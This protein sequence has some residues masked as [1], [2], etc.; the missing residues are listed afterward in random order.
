VTPADLKILGIVAGL[1]ML[2]G[3]RASA[4]TAPS[5]S[6]DIGTPTVTGSGSEAFGGTD[7]GTTRVIAPD[8]RL[9]VNQSAAAISAYDAANP[10]APA[11][12]AYGTID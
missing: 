4:A 5:G 6:V 11:S 7:Y 1:L 2:F 10:D 8:V 9:L 3:R 12:G